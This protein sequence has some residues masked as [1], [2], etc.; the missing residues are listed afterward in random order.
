MRI[1]ALSVTF[2]GLLIRAKKNGSVIFVVTSFPGMLEEMLT[3]YLQD[4][5]HPCTFHLGPLFQ[6][7]VTHYWSWFS[8]SGF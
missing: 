6:A 3:Q 5:C 2:Q 8:H 7:P 4:S 1:S